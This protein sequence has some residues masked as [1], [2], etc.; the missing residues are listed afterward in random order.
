[1]ITEIL[2]ALVKL[3]RVTIWK[4]LPKSIT[5]HIDPDSPM[6]D[7]ISVVI[8]LLFIIFIAWVIVFLG[9]QVDI[10]SCLDH[11]GR[12]EYKIGECEF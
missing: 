11:G 12:W 9:E 2:E 6:G 4:I 3:S 5:R 10:D 1:M 7:S 8:L